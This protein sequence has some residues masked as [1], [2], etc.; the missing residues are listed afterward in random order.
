MKANL[1][2]SNATTLAMGGG[3]L[4]IAFNA[5]FVYWTA[6][7]NG[8]IQKT[9]IGGGTTTSIVTGQ[10]G[11]WDLAVDATH[12]YWAN[13]KAATVVQAGLDGSN[14]TILAT[15]QGGVR[16][17][18]VDSTSVYWG[19]ELPGQ[20][21]KANLDGTDPVTLATTGSARRRHGGAEGPMVPGRLLRP[22]RVRRC[23]KLTDGRISAIGSVR[24]AR[25]WRDVGKRGGEVL[26]DLLPCWA[27]PRRGGFRPPA[28]LGD[29]AVRRLA[30]WCHLEQ[31]GGEV[32]FDLLPSRAT[33]RR[34]GFRPP[35]ISGDDS[36]RW[37]STSCHLGRRLDEVVST[38]CHLGR[39]LGEV[40]GDVLAPN[41]PAS[42]RAART[43]FH[44]FWQHRP[45][46]G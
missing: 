29:G 17:V 20:L 32:V 39:R 3:A 43:D 21:I 27:T 26:F 31:R 40:V 24:W 2:G 9:P 46:V 42:L 19:N 15:G 5:G 30:R 22:R 7:T 36:A 28:M 12:V 23:P 41:A 6:Y 4:G 11:P 18:L 10:N 44:H 37:F 14:P 45:R 25:R 34:G 1:D 8:A 13:Y 16:S 33:T 35:A 38:S